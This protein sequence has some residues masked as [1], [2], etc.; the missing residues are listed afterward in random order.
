MIVEVDVE[1]S[2][3]ER[4]VGVGVV[5]KYKPRL[6][7]RKKNEEYDEAKLFCAGNVT[8]DKMICALKAQLSRVFISLVEFFLCSA[9]DCWCELWGKSAVCVA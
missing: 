7:Q 5:E 8:R 3:R 2:R 1:T 9:C 6:Q 4:G